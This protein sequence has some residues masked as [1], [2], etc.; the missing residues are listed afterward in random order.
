MQLGQAKARLFAL[1]DET[2][3]DSALRGRLDHF[4]DIGQREICLYYPIYRRADYAAE[5]P[6]T[7]PQDCFA[8]VQLI[9]P[10]G[11][12]RAADPSRGLPQGAFTLLYQARP[13]PIPD[14]APD[15]TPLSLPD[16]AADALVYFVAA[17]CMATE[18][19]QR[20]FQN[21]FAE[22]QGRLAGLSG[23]TAGPAA[24]VEVHPYADL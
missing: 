24:V 23:M 2:E 14:G 7:L 18:Q 20:F 8:P 16:E 12:A 4:F 17:Q 5:D 3:P 21:F 19:D 10:D 1:M 22:Y 11:T 6:R 9:A 13:D 15:D